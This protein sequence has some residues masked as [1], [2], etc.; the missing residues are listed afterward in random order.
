[1]KK[2]QLLDFKRAYGS[3]PDDALARRFKTSKSVVARLANQ[4][5]LAKDKRAFP[6]LRMPRWT[7]RDLARLREWYATSSNLELAKTF[8]RSVSSVVSKAHG[9]GLN[10]SPERLREMGRQNVAIRRR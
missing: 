10:K 3:T 8:G 9:L 5:R 4:H 2:N 1:M 7:E 6:G